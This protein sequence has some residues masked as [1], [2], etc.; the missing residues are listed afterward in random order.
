MHQEHSMKPQRGIERP[1]RGHKAVSR[2]YQVG[3]KSNQRIINAASIGPA[4]P[5]GGI[6]YASGGRKD[7]SKRHR[8]GL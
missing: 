7:A 8:G 6:T 2:M 3:I 5:Q 4:R 1:L